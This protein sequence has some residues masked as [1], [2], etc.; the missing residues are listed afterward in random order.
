MCAKKNEQNAT[1]FH[2]DKYNMNGIDIL[3]GIE[4]AI[5]R[6]NCSNLNFFMIE[7][8]QYHN[9]SELSKFG[10][11]T[12]FFLKFVKNVLKCWKMFYFFF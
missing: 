6:K 9:R 10:G 2:S 8:N 11:F 1:I 3:T 5:N 7:H 12:M 4:T